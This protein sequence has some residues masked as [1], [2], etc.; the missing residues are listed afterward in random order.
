MDMLMNK[1]EKAG[2]SVEIE[3]SSLAA[4]TLRWTDR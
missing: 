3:S 4:F 1:Y 2:L